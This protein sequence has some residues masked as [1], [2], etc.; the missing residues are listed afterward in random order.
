[1]FEI[2]SNCIYKWRN[3]WSERWQVELLTLL[4]LTLIRQIRQKFLLSCIHGSRGSPRTWGYRPCHR[5]GRWTPSS[6]RT[7]LVP[8]SK[9]W[10]SFSQKSGFFHR[11]QQT[12]ANNS[13][14]LKCCV[15]KWFWKEIFDVKYILRLTSQM[16][17]S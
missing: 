12:Q 13:W 1:M 10:Q 5:I 7:C 11:Y 14:S 8:L 3:K 4:W 16:R 15:A 2:K 9:S 17:I 6:I